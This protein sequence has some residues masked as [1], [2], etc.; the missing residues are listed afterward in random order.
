MSIN[1]IKLAYSK[2]KNTILSYKQMTQRFEGDHELFRFDTKLLFKFEIKGHALVFYVYTEET[3]DPEIYHYDVLLDEDNKQI[4]IIFRVETIT[5]ELYGKL[6]PFDKVVGY[7]DKVMESLNNPKRTVYVPVAYAERYLVNP[8]AVLRGKEKIAPIDGQYDF[9]EY[10]PIMGELVRNIIDEL[11]GKDFDVNKKKGKEHLEALRLQSETIKDAVA[12][13]EPIV[14]FYDAALNADSSCAFINVQQVLN[15]KF[16]GKMLPQQ[17]TAI[18]EN[19]DKIEDLNFFTLNEVLQNCIDNEKL[20]FVFAL[21]CKILAKKKSLDKLTKLIAKAPGNLIIA[22]NCSML[23]ALGKVG[24][25]GINAIHNAGAEVM[26]DGIEN[27]SLKLLTEYPIEYLRFDARYFPESEQKRATFLD[28]IVGYANVQAIPTIA[29][30]VDTIKE[31]QFFLQHNVGIIQG[32][33]ACEPKRQIHAAVKGA[34]KLP[35]V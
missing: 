3:P 9:E 34:K 31:V 14:Y 21:S 1:D 24:L 2:L 33:A 22:L 16:L 27:V 13:T 4:A 12:I 26:L 35:K 25:D 10:D 7:I 20:R 29:M 11:L 30:Y 28:M 19:S 23:E 5:E 17:Y 15:D 6:T 18:A 32:Y 8:Q